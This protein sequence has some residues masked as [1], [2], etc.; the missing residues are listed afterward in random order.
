MLRVLCGTD[1]FVVIFYPGWKHGW[2]FLEAH[3]NIFSSY[4]HGATGF[5]TIHPRCS[6]LHFPVF[7][8]P[9]ACVRFTKM[10]NKLFR[11][12]LYISVHRFTHSSSFW[13]NIQFISK[14]AIKLVTEN[15]LLQIILTKSQ[16]TTA[17]VGWFISLW[18]RRSLDPYVQDNG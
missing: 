4:H 1:V 15:K 12:W 6:L 8:I 7:P 17:V 9:T 3:L 2:L 13:T 5:Q 10:E 14:L 16:P 11:D 18:T